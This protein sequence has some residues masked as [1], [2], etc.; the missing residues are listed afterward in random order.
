MW[1]FE[2]RFVGIDGWKRSNK[3]PTDMVTATI[4]AGQ[5]MAICAENSEI[6]EVRLV[7]LS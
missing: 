2:Y 5:W 3:G 6:I 1:T 4:R 7:S